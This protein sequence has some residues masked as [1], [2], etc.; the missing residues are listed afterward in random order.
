MSCYL[1][2][3]GYRDKACQI[4]PQDISFRLNATGSAMVRSGVAVAVASIALPQLCVAP[5]PEFKDLS[6]PPWWYP[7]KKPKNPLEYNGLS[8]MKPACF[9]LNGGDDRPHSVY[10]IGDWGGVLYGGSW[11]AP[12]D[13]RSAQFKGHSR[14]FIKGADDFAQHK[15]AD[16]MMDHAECKCD[17]QSALKLFNKQWQ[18][19]RF[20]AQ[21]LQAHPERQRKPSVTIVAMCLWPTRFFADTVPVPHI[22][23]QFTSPIQMLTEEE[24]GQ[25]LVERKIE[26]WKWTGSGLEE[27]WKWT[28]SGLEEDWKWTGSGLE[29]DWKRTGRGLEVDW[30]WTGSGLEE[31]WKW[32]GRGL[33]VDWKRTGSGLEVDWKWTGSGLEVDWKRTGSG[34]EVD[35]KRTGRGLEEDWKWTGSGLEVD[36]KWTGSGLEAF[37]QLAANLDAQVIDQ[38]VD[39][40][41]RRLV[42]STG[43]GNSAAL[44]ACCE[45]SPHSSWQE[46][47]ALKE[48]ELADCREELQR[49]R[50]YSTALE[51]RDQK[52]SAAVHLSAP[53]LD[54]VQKKVSFTPSA[55]QPTIAA[56]NPAASRFAQMD[57]E[58]GATCGSFSRQFKPWWKV[59][60]AAAQSGD[61][62]GLPTISPGTSD[63]DAG[64]AC[65]GKNG[66][67]EAGRC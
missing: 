61:L 34:L 62:Q 12:A 31:D 39:E 5:P 6:C 41:N 56:I 54:Q 25:I 46:L 24:Q 38:I 66:P 63:A 47:L 36:W 10:V 2:L 44:E 21:K 42:G 49:L 35:W 16:A 22:A 53:M 64:D 29:V 26:D 65:P 43:V 13:H 51:E 37:R 32:T 27:D 19:E 17:L 7:P 9:K 20:S 57:W 11:V 45:S 8:D 60:G 14:A 3:P 48:Q 1:S 18:Q 33:E 67:A 23:P 50:E 4:E 52:L 59:Y 28:G 30:K 58:L 40:H 15:V 55:V